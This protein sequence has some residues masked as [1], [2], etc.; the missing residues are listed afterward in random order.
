VDRNDGNRS[1]DVPLRAGSD[2]I[3]LLEREAI[4]GGCKVEGV[5]VKNYRLNPENVFGPAMTNVTVDY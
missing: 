4:L 3:A 1:G 5:V 2:Q